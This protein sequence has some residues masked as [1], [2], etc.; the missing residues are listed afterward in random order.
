MTT[1]KNNKM[2]TITYFYDKDGIFADQQPGD[3]L[4]LDN[5]TDV[6]PPTRMPDNHVA[7][8]LAE[9]NDWVTCLDLST[10]H[11]RYFNKEYDA[12]ESKTRYYDGKGKNDLSASYSNRVRLEKD[13][14]QHITI[15][16][17]KD[18][19]YVDKYDIATYFNDHN[20]NKSRASFWAQWDVSLEDWVVN[21]AAVIKC[22]K[23]D[24]FV[25]LPTVMT[26]LADYNNTKDDD[27]AVALISDIE[28]KK[29]QKFRNQAIKFLRKDDVQFDHSGNIDKPK[30]DIKDDLINDIVFC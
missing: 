25:I 11:G 1:I 3:Q 5:T 9:K 30:L 20:E 12:N 24:L 26:L 8:F 27:K 10:Y 13:L 6:A 16:D 22:L 7:V 29:L 15:K 4:H 2:T 19:P 17:P 23:D 14:P 18:S 28:A 21:Q